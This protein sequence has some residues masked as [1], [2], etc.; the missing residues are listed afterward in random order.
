M[1]FS[2]SKTSQ[3]PGLRKKEVLDKVDDVIDAI[4]GRDLYPDIRVIEGRSVGSTIDIEGKSTLLFCGYDYLGLATNKEISSAIKEGLDKYGTQSGGTPLVSGTLD[5]HKRA[6]AAVADLVGSETAM[7][8]TSGALANVGVI[9]AIMTLRNFSAEFQIKK[10]LFMHDDAYIFSDELNHATIVDGCRL[11]K[12]RI[13][14]YKHKDM[15]DLAR[16]LAG[17]KSSWKM[18]V[19]DGV[20][21]MDGDIAPLPDLVDLS[22]KHNCWLVVD[23]AHSVGVLGKN[24]EGT[25]GHF[26]ITEGIDVTVGALG[27][28]VSILGGYAAVSTKVCE[29][30]RITARPGIFSGSLPPPLACGLLK[31]VEIVKQSDS[32]RNSLVE[33]GDRLR[34][35]FKD[36]GLNT[37]YSE[38][39]T[40][41]IPLMIGEDEKAIQVSRE[42]QEKGFFAPAIR[43][44][45]VPKKTARIRFTV[46][47]N[48]TPAQVDGLIGCVKELDQKYGFSK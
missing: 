34:N 32:L 17:V 19:T 28:A 15:D 30:L 8:F 3:A 23:D 43:W 25:A 26:G 39:P 29:V 4:R 40:P 1:L 44:P 48:N 46:Q 20:F 2:F 37:L 6:E 27:K 14:V 22:R 24:G 47:A 11:S 13:V 31:S 12:A 41:I 36:L 9:P 16:K 5:V 45:A 35:G 42:L 21:S 18:I 7:L 33:N 38:T 10:F